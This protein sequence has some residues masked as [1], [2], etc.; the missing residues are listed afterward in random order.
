MLAKT[1][2]KQDR[3]PWLHEARSLGSVVVTVDCAFEQ[4]RPEEFCVLE[5]CS[6]RI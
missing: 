4:R 3:L 5:D 1:G 2:E 6:P